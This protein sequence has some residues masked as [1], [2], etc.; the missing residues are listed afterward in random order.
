M[1]RSS[2]VIA[3]ALAAA[4]V[5]AGCS[6]S[7]Y[8][9]QQTELA[10]LA[11]T[12][13]ET[14]GQSVEIKQDPPWADAPPAAQPV[15]SDTVIFVGGGFNVHTGGGH[16]HGGGGHGGGGSG[17]KSG[18]DGDD[19]KA[20]AI[21]I[22]VIALTAV[23]VMAVVEGSRF[24]GHVQLH[25][26]HPVHLYLHDGSYGVVP[27]AGLTPELVPSVRRAV[28]VDREGPWHTLDRA[29]L[30]RRGLTYSVLL[31]ANSSVSADGDTGLGFSSHI[32]LGYFPTQQIGIVGDL[33]F[34]WRTNAVEETL[35]DTRS[36]LELQFWPVAV[37]PL[38]GGV[39][40]NAG[41]AQRIEDGLPG[42][43]HRG[44]AASGGAQVQIDLTTYL[45]LTARFGVIHAHDELTREALVGVSVY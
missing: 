39:F 38:H 8:N 24:V 36:A 28:V 33:V 15:Q 3:V 11:A 9:I 44:F 30:D 43:N 21:A 45:A 40:G 16:S 26:M 37:G 29:P 27:L 23:V 12:P 34:G 13:P 35:F 18:G 32:Q 5:H 10:R 4:L 6:A 19:A 17:V 7:T 22:V 20:T 31:G 25:P 14:R 2:S 1:T 41:F 42:G